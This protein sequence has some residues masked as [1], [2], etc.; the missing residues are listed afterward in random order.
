[1]LCLSALITVGIYPVSQVSASTKT[2]TDPVRIDSPASFSIMGKGGNGNEETP[3]TWYLGATPADL[4][5]DA[6]V[7]LFVPGLN[8]VAQIFWEDNDMYQTAYH[9]GYQTAFVQLYDAGG[10]SADMW[11]NG[12][13]LA[14]KITEISN[15]F[16]GKDITI[17]AYSKGGV[18]SQAAL[19]YY[20]ASDYVDNVITLSSPHHGSQLADLA[21]SSDA[22]WLADLI[23]M[24]GEGT[25]SMQM[26]YMENFRSETDTNPNAYVNDYFT[27]G[28]TDWGAVFSSN[29]F[30]GM[31][32]SSYGPNDGVVTARSSNLPG[33]YELAIRE[34]NHA[35]IRTG[36]TFPTFQDYLEGDQLPPAS[37]FSTQTSESESFPPKANQWVHGAPLAKKDVITVNVE[38]DV[39]KLTINL[40][41]AKQLSKLKV[42][43]PSGK[44]A[45]TNVQQI[46]LEE[47]IFKDAVS[48]ALTIENPEAGEWQ[49]ELRTNTDDNAY[50]LVA[51]LKK[52][53]YMQAELIKNFTMQDDLYQLNIDTK[54]LIEDSLSA[55]YH[56][57]E[58][59]K[60]NNEKKWTVKGK[61]NLSQ[62]LKLDKANTVY[63]I[64][65]DIEGITNDGHTFKRT[66]VDSVYGK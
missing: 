26:A 28:G 64:T 55:T 7:L 29:W 63:N 36:I 17:V 42:T 34:W 21:Y 51:D 2:V 10:E 27:L 49:L 3:G 25:Y 56:L 30:G 53:P 37:D 60:P 11:N 39:E 38:E 65:V 8:N 66:I 19:T 57:T 18:D 50:L 5:P 35:T 12:R 40:L 4:Q 32:L 43:N 15:H 20:G 41:T 13:L 46:H 1:M 45:K 6:P 9:A 14:E 48:S 47:G 16:G 62:Q 44:N 59:A 24:Q 33:G 58:S 22:G 54:H 23:G 61:S 31:Y 52:E